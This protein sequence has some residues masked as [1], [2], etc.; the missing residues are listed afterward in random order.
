MIE[1]IIKKYN[2]TNIRQNMRD[3]LQLRMKFNVFL[4]IIF[5]ENKR[6]YIH[7]YYEKIYKY[8]NV[9]NLNS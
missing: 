8:K 6:N 2:I 3:K 5:L 7:F 9:I 1:V 4:I